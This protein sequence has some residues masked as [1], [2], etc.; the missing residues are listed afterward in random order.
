MEVGE[1]IKRIKAIKDNTRI[2][3]ESTNLGQGEL[4]ET[5]SPTKEH[6]WTGLKPPKHNVQKFSVVFLWNL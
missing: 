2:P 5:E 4:T 3:T 6:A 1:R